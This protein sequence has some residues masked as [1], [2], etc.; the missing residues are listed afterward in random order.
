MSRIT[1]SYKSTIQLLGIIQ[2]ILAIFTR[3]HNQK[4]RECVESQ[5]G[6]FQ[7]KRCFQ[8][9]AGQLQKLPHSTCEFIK[10]NK[11]KSQ[12]RWRRCSWS[13][14]PRWTAVDYWWILGREKYFSL[15][16]WPL[17][18]SPFA[19]TWPYTHVRPGRTKGMPWVYNKTYEIGRKRNG[20]WDK[21]GSGEKGRRHE[22]W[23]KYMICLR[24]IHKLTK[25]KMKHFFL[26]K[27]SC[28]LPPFIKPL[29]YDE[30]YL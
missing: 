7:E 10:S 4:R 8:D 20:R 24:A 13:A 25:L 12:Q 19:S 16:I 17:G 11:T 22:F 14:I 15:A 9:M 3:L 29:V 23:S 2:R 27:L 26:K 5:N 6:Q 21:G 28:F 30:L 1:L 18:G